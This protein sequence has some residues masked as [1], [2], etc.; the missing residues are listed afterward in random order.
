MKKVRVFLAGL[1]ATSMALGSVL[2]VSAATTSGSASSGSLKGTGTLEGSV[3]T[4]IVKVVVPVRDLNFAIDP[5]GLLVRTGAA[6]VKLPTG[7][8][9]LFKKNGKTI[10]PT[11]EASLSGLVLFNNTVYNTDGK[12]IK[13]IEYTNSLNLQLVNKSS[14]DIKVTPTF[15]ATT[16]SASDI[17]VVDDTAAFAPDSKQIYFALKYKDENK[18]DKTLVCNKGDNN[19]GVGAPV[20]SLG[21]PKAYVYKYDRA[22]KYELDEK[23]KV[24]F[25]TV[26]FTLVAECNSDADWST[27]KTKPII[28]VTWN[29][30]VWDASTQTTPPAVP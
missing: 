24:T 21:T 16:G 25:P 28:D 17:A 12:T 8:K 4:D 9:P 10:S 22:Y 14:C 13:S 30:E 29:F 6:K 7:I 23:L 5:Q 19:D 15:K 11:D 26:D 3:E 1:L 2:S 20:K 18:N 27:T